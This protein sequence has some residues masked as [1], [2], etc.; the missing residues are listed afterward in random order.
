MD[1]ADCR[2]QIDEIDRLFVDLFCRRMAVSAEIAAYKKAHHL[3][4]YIPERE[5]EKMASISDFVSPEMIPYVQSLY[6]TLFDLSKHYQE[7][8]MASEKNA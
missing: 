1:L 6:T 7:S 4:I 3:P 8:C 5:K 2:H